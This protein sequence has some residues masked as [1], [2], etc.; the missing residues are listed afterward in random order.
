MQTPNFRTMKHRP[1][2]SRCGFYPCSGLEDFNFLQRF[3]R[4]YMVQC[5]YWRRIPLDDIRSRLRNAGFEV[6]EFREMDAHE[7]PPDRLSRDDWQELT[8]HGLRITYERYLERAARFGDLQAWGVTALLIRDAE[9]VRFF[10]FG[11]E[12]L[13]TMRW[14]TLGMHWDIDALCLVNQGEGLGGNWA[15]GDW[16]RCL[17]AGMRAF[18]IQP[19]VVIAQPSWVQLCRPPFL[20]DNPEERY[21]DWRNC[22]DGGLPFGVGNAHE[23]DTRVVARYS[24]RVLDLGNGAYW[25]AQK[26]RKE[27]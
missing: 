25:D 6:S 22:K 10:H 13:S 14:I 19:S 21:H 1:G 17:D 24:E 4:P 8:A 16:P 18:R 27:P 20:I 9:A 5:D 3:T 26:H 15:S 23:Y 12:A 11:A 7:M 2:S